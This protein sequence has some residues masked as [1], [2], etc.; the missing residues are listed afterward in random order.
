MLTFSDVSYALDP[1][2]A[3]TQ[4]LHTSW[5]TAEGLPQNSISSI[6]QTRDG[7]LWL[8]TYEG[9]V[10]FD[11]VTFTVFD[12]GNTSAIKNNYIFA[13]CED[14]EGSLWVGTSG[15]LLQLKEGTFRRYT[16]KDGLS[17]DAILSICEDA[18]QALW[19][20][21]GNGLT[22][23]KNQSISRYST[24]DGLPNNIIDVIYQDRQARLWLG[25]RGGL[26]RFTNGTFSNFTTRDGLSDNVVYSI[27]QDHQ[28]S[29]WIGTGHGLTRL[30][31]DTFTVYTTKDGLSSDLI[32][33][34]LEDHEGNLWIGTDGG[35][36]N[37]WRQGKI[38]NFR[39]H[40]VLSD[41]HVM[42]LLEDLEGSLWIGTDG[43][44]LDRLANATF[45]TFTTAE[46]LS[47]DNAWSIYEDREGSVWIGTRNGGLNRLRDGTFTL[48]GLNDG[49][50]DA[51]V[52]SIFQDRKGSLW[53]GTDNGLK[54]LWNGIFKTYSMADGLL[55]KSVR[56][57]CEDGDGTLWIGTDGGLCSLRDGHFTPC[58]SSYGRGVAVYFIMRDH[59]DRLW[60]GTSAGLVRYDA[61]QFIRY[62]TRDGLPE[63]RVLSLH[64]DKDGT[65][66]IG[67]YGGGL[68]RYKN[69]RFDRFDTRDGLFSDV[70]FQI[71]EDFQENLWM[72]CNKGIFRVSKKEL[73]DFAEGKLASIVSVHYGT[74]DGMKSIECNGVSQPAGCKT[75]DG[76]LW[77]PTL[78]GVTVIDPRRMLT[79]LRPPPVAVEEVISDKK[80]VRLGKWIELAPGKGELEF[81]YTGLS[82]L[83]PH[84]NQFKYKLE[85]FDQE[86]IAAGTRRVAYYTNIP[87]GRYTFRVQGS[88]NDGVWNEQG[89]SLI[90]ALKPHYYQTHWF[91][92]ACILGSVLLGR[93]VYLARVNHLVKLTRALERRVADRTSELQLQKQNYESL[94]NSIEG[95]V[96]EAD[97][98]TLH[99]SFVSKQAERLLGYSAEQWLQDSYFYQEHILEEDRTKVLELFRKASQSGRVQELECRMIGASGEI[100][101]LRNIIVVVCENEV[102][103][104]LR[105]VMVDITKQKKAEEERRRI[106]AQLLRTQKQESLGVLA[107]GIAHHYNNL[108]TAIVG[109]AEL[110]MTD[111]SPGSRARNWIQQ[112]GVATKRAAELTHQM[113]AYSGK[114]RFVVQMI[115][116]SQI[117]SE[118]THLLE[119]SVSN[120]CALQYDLEENLPAVEVDAAQIRQVIMNLIINASEAMED[121]NG[122]I[123]IRTGSQHCDRAYL[124]ESYLDENLAVGEYVYLEVADTGCGMTAAIRSRIFDPFFTTKF[125]G[126]GLGLAAVLGIVRGHQGAIKIYSEPERGTTFRVLFPS[127]NERCVPLASL[128]D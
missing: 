114:G 22:R 13:I 59:L 46:G 21:T 79:N 29:L 95:I 66:W 56:A 71:L 119:L 18:T 58:N 98:G 57:V 86:W 8:G 9:L 85:G 123:A 38:A 24:A 48:Y 30:K 20:G 52:R 12:S 39:A 103:I 51:L 73:N 104:K 128:P 127:T 16:M 1:D 43:G 102:P 87:P 97:C 6:V 107:G 27:Q 55:D 15:G 2:K 100:V 37:R 10:R 11:G 115:N 60:I 76:R 94:V 105:G 67:T 99:F 124:S 47:T 90:I 111:L 78:K 120:K 82:L 26:S 61:K 4:F 81:H 45:T 126:R 122:M 35:G 53:V 36:L 110:A 125:T 72:S 68:S 109:N 34:M 33:S 83:A 63:D 112:I 19:L 32:W 91:L 84:R 25:T 40:D 75:R 23:I 106:E 41:N 49:L 74:E 117:I 64:E 89:A 88:N 14:K 3:I 77:F 108:L 70:I 121:R 65:L 69:G 28:G 50:S 62:T 5:Q 31:D 80:P 44:G 118:M 92:F 96:W 116:L 113:L 101:W 17:S 7:Y 93:A 54:Q 42:S